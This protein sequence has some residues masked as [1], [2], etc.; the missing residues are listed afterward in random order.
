MTSLDHDS[1]TVEEKLFNKM[2]ELIND[3]IKWWR[4]RK[5]WIEDVEWQ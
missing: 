1:R 5:G 3:I 2:Y 4:L